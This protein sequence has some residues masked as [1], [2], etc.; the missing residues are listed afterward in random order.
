MRPS[1]EEKG[2]GRIARTINPDFVLEKSASRE[3]MRRWTAVNGS[4]KSS[5]GTNEASFR[6]RS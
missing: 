4:S 5:I 1:D 3:S 2:A 6:E